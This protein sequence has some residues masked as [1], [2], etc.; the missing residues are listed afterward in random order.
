MILPLPQLLTLN[1]CTTVWMDE[2]A[3]AFITCLPEQLW[4]GEDMDR[5]GTPIDLTLHPKLPPHTASPLAVFGFRS[6]EVEGR[7]MRELGECG[8]ILAGK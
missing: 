7:L 5:H 8:R 4:N 1:K 3:I 6:L 2:I